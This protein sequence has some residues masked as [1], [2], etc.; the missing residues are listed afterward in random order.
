MA[1]F[2]VLRVLLAATLWLTIPRSASGNPT[3]PK[4]SKPQSTDDRE[5]HGHFDWKSIDGVY[6]VGPTFSYVSGTSG[7]WAAGMDLSYLFMLTEKPDPKK[8]TQGS[9]FPFSISLHL[10]AMQENDN[11][12]YGAHLEAVWAILVL[13]GGSGGYM[14]GS[15]ER[16]LNWAFF[17]ALPIPV[18]RSLNMG[19]LHSLVVLPYY[20]LN[21]FSGRR[22]HEFGLQV[23]LSTWK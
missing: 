22:I 21:W 9:A 3:E 23:K 14:Y 12:R 7:G 13:I 15:Q 11:I 5:R 17:T 4:P 19:P 18:T 20:R 10:Q 8:G 2:P 1:P 6:N 16:G